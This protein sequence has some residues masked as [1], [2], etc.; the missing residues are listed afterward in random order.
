MNAKTL[1]AD[2]RD[3]AFAAAELAADLRE[4]GFDPEAVTSAWPD[5]AARTRTV[6]LAAELA[7]KAAAFATFAAELAAAFAAD[8]D[9]G[10]SIE[11]AFDGV[12]SAE[13]DAAELAALATKV[14]DALE[15]KEGDDESIN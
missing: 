6:K 14:A 5:L 4:F 7:A 12:A 8:L 3:A 2:Q 1:T 11:F 10:E 13:G 9:S 15:G